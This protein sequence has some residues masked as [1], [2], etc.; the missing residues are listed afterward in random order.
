M[1]TPH[2]TIAAADNTAWVTLAHVAGVHGI[3]TGLGVASGPDYHHFRVAIDGT[4]LGA[5]FLAGTGVAGHVNNGLNVGLPFSQELTVDARDSPEPS[6]ITRYWVAYVTGNRGPAEVTN[7]VD[8]VAGSRYLY[9]VAR[10]ERGEG[11]THVIESLIGPART[12]R[13]RLVNDTVRLEDWSRDSGGYVQLLGDAELANASGEVL[14]RLSQFTGL[15]R[16]AGRHSILAEASFGE[17][18]S[19]QPVKLPVPGEYSVA[20]VL[21]DYSNIPAFFTA[22]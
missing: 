2:L 1:V 9:R 20:T 4:T 17:D 21:P 13:I 15:I 18:P 11:E 19:R 16:M 5:D 10:Y 8:V 22:L 6:S 12:A 7:R 14:E 3:L